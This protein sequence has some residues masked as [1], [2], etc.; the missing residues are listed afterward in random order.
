MSLALSYIYH[1][2]FCLTLK[3]T[4]TNR[5]NNNIVINSVGSTVHV[6]RKILSGAQDPSIMLV[7]PNRS[8]ILCYILIFVKKVR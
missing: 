5:P 1:I 6:T 2:R 8:I 3:Y 7:G 4:S